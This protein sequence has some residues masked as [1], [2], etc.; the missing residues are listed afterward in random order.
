MQQRREA[1]TSAEEEMEQRYK[2]HKDNRVKEGEN[3]EVSSEAEAEITMPSA[4]LKPGGRNKQ[5]HTDYRKLN[6]PSRSLL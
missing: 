2:G 3:Q 5:S 6:L 1:C 4:A